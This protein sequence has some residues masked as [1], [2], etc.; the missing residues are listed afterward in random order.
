MSS[1]V[2]K[3]KAMTNGTRVTVTSEPRVRWQDWANLLLG[4]WL[5]ISPWILRS[6]GIYNRDAWWVGALIFLVAVW[7]LA[8]PAAAVAEWSNILL[9]AGLFIAPW[10]LGYL[11]L[12]AAWNAWIVGALVFIL[13]I[14]ALVGTRQASRIP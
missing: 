2:R 4:A 11:T 12:T 1:P 14:W 10:V 13:A 7:A 5:F 3:G 9:G 6:S 8:M